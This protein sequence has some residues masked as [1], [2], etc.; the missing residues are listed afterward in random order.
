MMGK[1][2]VVAMVALLGVGLF[3]SGALAAEQ[4]FSSVSTWAFT[5]D[6]DR[7]SP[8][9]MLDLRPLNERFAGEHGFI[10]ISP[11]GDFVRGDGEPIRFWAV[12][13]SAWSTDDDSL[14]ADHARFLAKRG[15]NMVRWHANITPRGDSASITDF[16]AGA[17][18]KLWRYVATMKKEGIYM[19]ISPYWAA[20]VR[21][22][23]R[24][25][26]PREGQ[27]M[28]GL[29][30][31]DP[32]LQAAYKEWLR[33]MYQPVNPYTGIALKDDP[34]VAII[35]IQNEDSLLFWT[36]NNLKGEN[37]DLVC[38]QYGDWLARKYGSLQAASQAWQGAAVNGDDL[39]RGL[40]RF[41]NIWEMTE[42]GIK[43][44]GR[45]SG[46]RGRRMADQLE[47]WT[48]TM[49]RFN[50]EI[51]RFLRQEVGARQL[52]NPGNWKPADPVLLTDAERYSYTAGEVIAVN[53]YVGDTHIGPN[54][55]WAIVNGDRF[56]DRSVLVR[57]ETLGVSLKQVAGRPMIVT[58]SNWVLPR[59]YQSEGPFLVSVMESLNGVD[60]FYWFAFG[61]MVSRRPQWPSPTPQWRQPSSANGYL[62]SLMKWAADTPEILGNF[63]AAA[64]IYRL[65]YVQRARPVVHERRKLEDMWNL[66]VPIIAEEGSYDPNRDRG[67]YAPESSIKQE[68][69][70]LAF[71][72]GPVE[73]TYGDDPAR[74]EV[75]DL[76]PYI[77]ED[78]KVVRSA[79]HEVTWDYGRGLCMLSAPKAQGVS[80]FLKQVGPINL[81]DVTVTS[82]ND[83]ATIMVVA[84]DEQ[85]LASSQRILVQ[86]GTISR[87]TG[88]QQRP[89]TWTD[90][91]GR[92][93]EGYEVVNYGRA[94]WRI[95]SNDTTVV[96]RN[97]A[98]TQATV[99]DMNGMRRGPVAMERSG[100][101][102]SFRMP[103]D[104]KYVILHR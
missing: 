59:A 37:L 17:R 12:N 35:Q 21:P 103:P 4:D 70:R 45:P 84:M 44:L 96:L 1:G 46:G 81:G 91:Q 69:N 42:D 92:A 11:E 100:G 80:G 40:P 26:V 104:A 63:P 75:V 93:H 18:D 7:Y 2:T 73:V 8:D 76:S 72:V 47:F 61:G 94:P 39:G 51:V 78:A 65:G 95:I 101:A 24:W 43:Q 10:G 68:V 99:L 97:A 36:V 41:Y 60:A 13:T 52:V 98:L 28:H 32:A 56:Q 64:L 90:D 88:W 83:Y 25:G 55:G 15:V 87:P 16:D 82:G 66:R 27:D 6:V 58:E 20:S 67:D 74:S 3:A 34:A 102:I 79:T 22:G 53:R 23:A 14:L 54:Q 89:Q 19:T 49:Y 57:P 77:D 31:F 62:P 85:P 9:S 33:A 5:P 29:L 86:A 71:L 30:F 50:E 38:R 48:E